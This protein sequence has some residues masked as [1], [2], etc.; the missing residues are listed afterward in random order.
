MSSPSDYRL[1][2]QRVL[3]AMSPRYHNEIGELLRKQEVGYAAIDPALIFNAG[4]V[5]PMTGSGPILLEIN[6]R[7]LD[8][9]WDHIRYIIS[10]LTQRA[11]V[12]AVMDAALLDEI[13]PLMDVPLVEFLVWPGDEEELVQMLQ[14]IDL[15]ERVAEQLRRE[16]Q[17]DLDGLRSEVERI[18]NALSTLV[19]APGVAGERN[20]GEARSS[21][22]S[23]RQ[24]RG[25]IAQR[26]ARARFFPSEL[27]ADPAWD[28]L[29]DLAAARHEGTRVSISSLCI[30]AAV[31][32]TTGLRWIKALTEANLLERQ[33][34]PEDGR[35]SFITLTEK[36]ARLMERYLDELA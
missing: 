23:A 8:L 21:R 28:I 36:T 12:V 27:F 16:G 26:R 25:L 20:E 15:S 13:A 22:D 7:V 30:A 10:G 2:R 33:A 31:P 24:I 34:D 9:G 32:T 17:V 5:A 35:R 18:A 6:H 29:L 3:I 1:H 11:R 14:P 19:E 4:N